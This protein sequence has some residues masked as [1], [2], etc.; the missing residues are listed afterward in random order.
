MHQKEIRKE[1]IF[2]ILVQREQ[3]IEWIQR[4]LYLNESLHKEYDSFYQLLY[5]I[6]LQELLTEGLT[7]IQDKVNLLNQNTANG[8]YKWI[9]ILMKALIEIKS[10]FPENELDFIEYKRHNA[11]HIFQ[12]KYESI[13][14]NGKIKTER[15][16]KNIKIMQNEFQNILIKYKGDREFDIY[17]TS[18]LYPVLSNLHNT[19]QSIRNESE[20][21]Y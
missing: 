16:S 4:L 15:N 1:I 18:T 2:K 3:L 21:C 5:Y 19:L 6:N 17:L 13:Q 7:Y 20:K 11:C 12:N 9:S 8:N 14:N 10:L